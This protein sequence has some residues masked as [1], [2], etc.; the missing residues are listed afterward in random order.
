MATGILRLRHKDKLNIDKQGCDRLFYVATKI[1]TQGGE[2]LLRHNKLGCDT[3]MSLIQKILSRHKNL[4]AIENI[5]NTKRLYHNIKMK[6][7]QEIRLSS[8]KTLS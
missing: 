4:V 5:D 7:Q 1:P 6:L 8:D 2:V 3:K